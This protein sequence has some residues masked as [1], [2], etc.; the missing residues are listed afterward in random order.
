MINITWN[1]CILLII[2]FTQFENKNKIT[3]EITDEYQWNKHRD[4]IL[5]ML[6]NYQ[7]QGCQI[8]HTEEGVAILY[9]GSSPVSLAVDLRNEAWYE[10]EDET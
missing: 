8:Y 4:W 9:Q 2:R 10:G 1:Y 7:S 3:Q 6:P 5:Q